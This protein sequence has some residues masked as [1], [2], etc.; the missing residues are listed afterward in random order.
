MFFKS[1]CDIRLETAKECSCMS[2]SP[3]RNYR[4]GL[5]EVVANTQNDGKLL[6]RSGSWMTLRAVTAMER[7]LPKFRTS[8]AMLLGMTA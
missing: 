5:P 8:T 3:S 4:E 2:R 6:N 1:H 7:N